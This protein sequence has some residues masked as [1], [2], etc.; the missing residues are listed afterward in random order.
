MQ[1]GQ[2]GR[3]CRAS[4]IPIRK[5]PYIWGDLLEPFAD[6]EFTPE[7][8]AFTLSRLHQAGLTDTEIDQIR[9]KPGG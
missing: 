1:R 3:F 6:T 7:Y 5:R 9:A 4:Q 2:L 8:E